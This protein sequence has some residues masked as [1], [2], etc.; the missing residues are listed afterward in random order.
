MSSSTFERC[1]ALDE[2]AVQTQRSGE[3]SRRLLAHLN[4]G[5]TDE[6]AKV[7]WEGRSHAERVGHSVW[8]GTRVCRGVGARSS[9]AEQQGVFAPH[10]VV[11]GYS[12]QHRAQV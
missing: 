4:C 9:T 10:D 8:E 6:G 11:P 5:L 1:V 2:F 7:G 3:A 12:L